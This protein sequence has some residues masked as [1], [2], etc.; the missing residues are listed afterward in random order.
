MQHT[1]EQWEQLRQCVVML[2]EENKELKAENQQLKQ[3]NQGLL[4]AV[5][6]L[7]WEE[8]SASV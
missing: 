3:T 2:H 4:T 7:R 8:G 6:S 1:E 5:A